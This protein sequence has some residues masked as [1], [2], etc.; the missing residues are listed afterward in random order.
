[1]NS[2]IHQFVEFS[3]ISPSSRYIFIFAYI[4]LCAIRSWPKMCESFFCGHFSSFA[5]ELLPFF[6]A[7]GC[8]RLSNLSSFST[9]IV[10]IHE[11]MINRS[12]D[13]NEINWKMIGGKKRDKSLKYTGNWHNPNMIAPRKQIECFKDLSSRRAI[14]YYTWINRTHQQQQQL[15]R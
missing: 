10:N 14:R 7:C 1:M 13:L 12:I 8:V 11:M 9:K 15:C 6:Y 4:W 2:E 5:I 3:N